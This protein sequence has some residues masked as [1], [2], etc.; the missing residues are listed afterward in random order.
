VPKLGLWEI[1]IIAFIILL[2][3]GGKRIPEMMRGLGEGIRH[4]KDSLKGETKPEEK[5]KL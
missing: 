5:P 3:F 1:L 2:L 4:F